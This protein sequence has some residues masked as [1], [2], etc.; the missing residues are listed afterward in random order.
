[1]LLSLWHW[2]RLLLHA[3]SCKP[4]P[5]CMQDKAEE[6][7]EGYSDIMTAD[8]QGRMAAKMVRLAHCQSCRT[9]QRPTSVCRCQT[10]VRAENGGCQ[11]AL[12][13]FPLQAQQYRCSTCANAHLHGL[14]Y[15]CIRGCKRHLQGLSTFTS[16]HTEQHV[17]HSSLQGLTE[18]NKE[19][20]VRLLSAMY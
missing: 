14:L 8:Y 12:L 17:C 1:M 16:A 19:L 6:L 9:A 7:L 5:S 2:R 3:G 11:H 20:A 15:C 4:L 13:C 18:Y 10:P